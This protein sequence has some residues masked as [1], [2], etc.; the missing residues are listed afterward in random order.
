[1]NRFLNT[2]NFK[3]HESESNKPGQRICQN[4][5]I[6]YHIRKRRKPQADVSRKNFVHAPRN[7]S[8]NQYGMR[9]FRVP[10]LDRNGNTNDAM[11]GKLKFGRFFQKLDDIGLIR[12]LNIKWRTIIQ[13]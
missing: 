4:T 1:M 3:Y 10:Q 5:R 12:I 6:E 9:R 7:D 11:R 8:R 2:L 13:I